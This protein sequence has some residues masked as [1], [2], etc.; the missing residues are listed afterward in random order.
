MRLQFD[1]ALG[2][3]NEIGK[4]GEHVNSPIGVAIAHLGQRLGGERDLFDGA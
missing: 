1:F 3:A 2:A 4:A